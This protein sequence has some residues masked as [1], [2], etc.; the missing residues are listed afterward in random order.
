MI[1]KI[2]KQAFAVVLKKPFKLWGI[3]LLGGLLC[4][5]SFGLLVGVPGIALAIS[6]AISTSITMI[7]LRGYR[8]EEIRV[9]DLFECLK[10]WKTIKRVVGGMAWMALWIFLWGLIPVVG[11]IFAVIKSYSWRLTPYI[12]VLEDEVK[13]TDAIKVS[14][15]RTYG[16]RGKMFGA[17][18]LAYVVFW[19]A[20]F[21]IGFVF[22]F[23]GGLVPDIAIFCTFITAIVTLFISSLLPLFMGLV[24]SAFYEEIM[25]VQ[26]AQ[27]SYYQGGYNNGYAQ[28]GFNGGYAQPGSYDPYA[29]TQQANSYDPY[30]QTQQAN[31]YDPYAQTQQANSYDPYAQG[32]RDQGGEQ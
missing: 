19:L 32:N 13:I 1:T 24:Q 9:L 15:R 17:E 26:N 23:I 4:S 14:E 21:V 30:A 2:F 11:P 31:S 25:N 27:N 22:G 5:L 16:Y 10:D 29:R 3:I 28:P 6:L 18:I 12:L 7:F 8:G 20:S